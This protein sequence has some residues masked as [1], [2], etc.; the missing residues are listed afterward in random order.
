MDRLFT[1]VLQ[2]WKQSPNRKPLIVRGARQV[3][4]TYTIKQF[5]ET[6]FRGRIHVV[7]FEKH[8][9]WHDVFKK[10]LDPVRITSELEILLNTRIVAGSDLLFFDEIQA[11]PKAIM[12]LRCFYE[13]LPGSSEVCI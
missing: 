9:D 1:K 8:P 11:A 13:E 6:D 7:D 3:G 12:A 5:G 10:D 2:D 4:K